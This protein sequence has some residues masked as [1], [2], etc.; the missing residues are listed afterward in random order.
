MLVMLYHHCVSAC[1][2]LFGINLVGTKY[3]NKMHTYEREGMLNPNYKCNC[4]IYVRLLKLLD[5][6][7]HTLACYMHTSFEE[8]NGVAIRV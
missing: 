1:Y 3:G 7:S 6:I 4:H 2:D 8:K 5:I